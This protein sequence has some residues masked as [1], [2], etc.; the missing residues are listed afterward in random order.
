MSAIIEVYFAQCI[1]VI[2]HSRDVSLL[3]VANAS[4]HCYSEYCGAG[5]VTALATV[6]VR[7]A[8]AAL[9]GFDGA[10]DAMVSMGALLLRGVCSVC[11][12]SC[13]IARVQESPARAVSESVSQSVSGV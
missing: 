6:V 3:P 9:R 7:C 1:A 5:E 12:S 2:L 13:S 11:V 4:F 10:G 8:T